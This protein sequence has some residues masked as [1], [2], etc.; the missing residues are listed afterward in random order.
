M[1]P[2]LQRLGVDKNELSPFLKEF[3]TPADLA[4]A[5]EDYTSHASSDDE[6]ASDE[7]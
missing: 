3:E 7:H 2:L 5:Y 4:M 1:T 6:R